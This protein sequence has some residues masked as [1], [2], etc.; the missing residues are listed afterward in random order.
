MKKV[1][2]PAEG[3]LR[4]PFSFF[5]TVATTFWRLALEKISV[6][7]QVYSYVQVYVGADV[8][9]NV[10]FFSL[11]IYIPIVYGGYRRRVDTVR[12]FWPYYSGVNIT[13]IFSELIFSPSCWNLEY[14]PCKRIRL[15]RKRYIQQWGF[16]SA[17]SIFTRNNSF[18]L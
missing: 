13:N 9:V 8:Y 17:A 6:H 18:L 4:Y 7:P 14:A 16:D 1:P 10:V 15:S 3:W 2:I 5:D 11:Y 12:L